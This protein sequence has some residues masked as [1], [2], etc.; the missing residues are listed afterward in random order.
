MFEET[1]DNMTGVVVY[2]GPPR[3]GESAST[4]T[5]VGASPKSD[6]SVSPNSFFSV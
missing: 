3:L 2:F 4:P 1:A 5:S 6:E